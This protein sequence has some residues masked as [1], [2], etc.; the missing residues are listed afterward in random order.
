MARLRLSALGVCRASA[1]ACVLLACLSGCGGDVV[2]LGSS[3]T[4]SLGGNAGSGGSA[5]S[6]GSSNQGGTGSV[7]WQSTRLLLAHP[8][9]QNLSFANG[10]L[11]FEAK[12]LYFTE[13]DRGTTKSIIKQAEQTDIAYST[14][15][16]LSFGGEVVQDASSPAISLSGN[17]LWFGS[18]LD[19]S[20]STDVWFCTGA[21]D[22]WSMPEKVAALNSEFDDAPRQPAVKD[23]IMPLSSKRHGGKH[24][25]IYFAQRDSEGSPWHEPTQDFLGTINSPDYESVDAFLTD[26]GLTLYFSSTR[27]GS[28]DLYRARRASMT[29]PFGEPERFGPNT[30]DF[31]ER[32][33]WL[34]ESDQRLFFS[35]NRSGLYEIY[36]VDVMREP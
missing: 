32:D 5:G 21:A 13:Q 9:D 24:Y 25:Q 20:S 10:T 22:S 8:S 26:N 1:A 19:G 30:D 18:R 11:T 14:P 6:S 27:A 28:A 29:D 4:L 35:S 7:G 31:D 33:P 17:Q 3:G 23:T 34:R 16:E 36:Q 12:Q 15:R 2:N